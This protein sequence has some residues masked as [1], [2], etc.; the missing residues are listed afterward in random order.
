MKGSRNSLT[1]L[2]I[3]LEAARTLNF[4][5]AAENLH[6]TQ[7]AVSKHVGALEDRLGC[8]LFKRLP[9]GLRLTH[10]G[11]LYLER[12]A[13]GMRLIDEAEA[14]V[15]HPGSRV[16]LNLAVSPSFAQFCLI[17]GL[18]A[19][20]DLHPEVRVNVRPRL[21]YGRDRAERFDAEIQLHTGHVAGMSAQYLCGREM[22]LV[23]APSLLARTPI[24]TLEDLDH[25]PLLKRAQRGYGWDEWKADVA[26]LWSGPAASAAEYEGFSVLLPAVLAGLGVAIVPL[27]M[28]L[29]PLR[30]GALLRP[31][32]EIVEGRYGYF[33]LQPRP[34]VGGPYAEALCAWVSEQAEAL[35]ARVKTLR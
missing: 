4:S 11:A 2:R 5:R 8:P 21:L 7:S 16:A 17:P 26:P 31:L 34:N 3:F 24:R 10:A 15:A 13:A 25:A 6:L 12:V 35:N 33:L 20:F 1:S 9:V 18:R 22:T 23:A 32:G 28:V 19:F 29:E 27:C 30:A 14:M